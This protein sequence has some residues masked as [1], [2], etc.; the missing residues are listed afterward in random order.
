MNPLWPA[1]LITLRRAVTLIPWFWVAHTWWKAAAKCWSLLSVS[2]RRPVSSSHCWAPPWTSKRRR[3]RRWRKVYFTLSWTSF[4]GTSR[5][6]YLGFKH[7]AVT[8]PFNQTIGE[9]FKDRL[10]WI[11]KTL[12]HT[13]RV[14]LNR[15]FYWCVWFDF[16]SISLHQ[17]ILVLFLS[18][19][20]LLLPCNYSLVT[21]HNYPPGPCLNISPET[22]C[23]VRCNHRQ[24]EPPFSD[25]TALWQ[26][27]FINSL[28]IWWCCDE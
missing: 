18:T 1:S 6:W 2:I 19:N 24:P 17:P 20:I 26:T 28:M 15:N 22:L 7:S 11:L 25:D 27:G 16:T 8:E 9:R 21:D 14:Q 23:A 4:S 5:V 12:G 3:S 13:H 10:T